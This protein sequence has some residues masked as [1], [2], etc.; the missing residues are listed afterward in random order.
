MLSNT[1]NSSPILEQ[2]KDKLS[3]LQFQV[4]FEHGT[5]PPFN[6]D[7]FDHKEDGIYVSVVSGEP[8]FGSKDKF[9]SG[10]GWPSFS[11][12]LEGAPVKETTD[13][14]FGMVRTEVSCATDTIHLGHVFNDGPEEDGG[15]RYCINSAS[16]K[17][18]PKSE[19]TEE[20][21]KKF[22]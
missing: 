2:F 1:S 17:F 15:L 20:Q 16:L 12:A 21:I 10:T 19:L 8:L 7:Y 9:D 13:M 4:A 11:K 5:E 6:N 14:T 18:V 3:P 22:F